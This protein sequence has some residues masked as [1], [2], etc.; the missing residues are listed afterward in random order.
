MIDF[1]LRVILLLHIVCHFCVLFQEREPSSGMAFFTCYKRPLGYPMDT[2]TRSSCK[3]PP[4]PQHKDLSESDLLKISAAQLQ[5]LLEHGELTSERLVGVY[6]DQ[7]DRHNYK[8]ACLHAVISTIAREK[9]VKE[10]RKLDKERSRLKR[11]HIP[12]GPMYGIP[13]IIK[14]PY[15]TVSIMSLELIITL[16]PGYLVH[17]NIGYGHHLRL[18]RTKGGQSQKECRGC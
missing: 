5:T 13:I 17:S 3:K 9:A 10:A 1:A 15:P 18:I 12:R 11:K 7:I 2:A 8:G 6:L 14:V 16:T 4:K